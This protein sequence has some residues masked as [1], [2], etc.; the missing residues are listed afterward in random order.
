MHI[1]TL[2]IQCTDHRGAI[3][4][5]LR[6]EHGVDCSPTFQDLGELFVWLSANNWVRQPYEAKYPTGRY[7]HRAS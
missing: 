7:M 5:F 6:D 2:H 4:D 3:G 1:A